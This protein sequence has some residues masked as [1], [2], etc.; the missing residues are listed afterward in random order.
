MVSVAFEKVRRNLSQENR[1]EDKRFQVYKDVL[2]KDIQL[3]PVLLTPKG[4]TDIKIFDSEDK[5]TDRK[6]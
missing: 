2:D 5:N 6:L 4:T 1:Y 3:C